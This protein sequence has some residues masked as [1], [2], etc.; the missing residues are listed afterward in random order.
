VKNTKMYRKEKQ[1][2]ATAK[3]FELFFQQAL[4]CSRGKAHC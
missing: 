4:I 1:Q 2:E 3:N